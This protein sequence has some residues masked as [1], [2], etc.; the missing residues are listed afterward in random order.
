MHT[1]SHTETHM[2]ASLLIQR[3]TH[4]AG[5]KHSR[6]DFASSWS[7]R[8][9]DAFIHSTEEQQQRQQQ[10]EQQQQHVEATFLQLGMEHMKV[11][12]THTDTHPHTQ[13]VW[14]T[15]PFAG[16]SFRMWKT[17]CCL[18]IKGLRSVCDGKR[19]ACAGKK[20]IFPIF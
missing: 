14:H 17:F 8:R 3:A 6:F 19:I 7:R 12:P 15:H 16:E 10:L 11:P 13:S 2:L 9:V 18:Q 5:Q 20:Y 1:H 4:F